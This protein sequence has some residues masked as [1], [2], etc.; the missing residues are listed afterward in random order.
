MTGVIDRAART[1]IMDPVERLEPSVY[2]APTVDRWELALYRYGQS[3][4]SAPAAIL[5][6]GYACNR[7]FMDFDERYSLAR[8]L[9]Q[10]G[11]D[12]WVVEFR[13][14]GRSRPLRGCK[15]PGRWTFDD[16]ALIDVPTILAFVAHELGHRRLCW[17]G[18]SMGWRRPCSFHGRP[19]I[20]YTR[21]GRRFSRCPFRGASP[22]GPRSGCFGTWSAGP[23]RSTSA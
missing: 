7:H 11:F 4:P 13:G 5:A 10:R 12:T 16:L 22:S 20:S 3:D 2:F 9:A 21:S 19:T 6:G 18:H 17:I 15:Q 23:V 14:R 1:C 8:Y